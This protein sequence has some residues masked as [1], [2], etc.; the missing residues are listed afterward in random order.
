MD[1]AEWLSIVAEQHDEWVK[2]VKSFGEKNFAEDIV[3]ESYIALTK[4]AK[5]EQIIKDGKV[6]RGY[7]YFTLRSLF[8]Q[9]YNKKKKYK[10]IRLDDH[11]QTWQLQHEDNIEEQQ[12]Y[13]K[14][15]TMIDEVSEEWHW[16]DKKMWKLYSQTDM[17]IRKLAAETNISWVS[18]FNTLKNLKLDI[19]NKIQEDWD[20]L[21]NEDY[22]RI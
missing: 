17:S 2:I 22:E 9:Y 5:P 8:Y 10:K 6:S 18:I 4:Y 21:K 1:R 20:D 13:H 14:I 7:M 16:Y 19:K 11:E 3:M 12:A 15:C